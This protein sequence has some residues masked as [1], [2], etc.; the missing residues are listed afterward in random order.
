MTVNCTSMKK[1]K[2]SEL[3]WCN[4]NNST[5]PSTRLTRP[6][7]CSKSNKWLTLSYSR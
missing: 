5:W 2:G 6:D 4:A 7:S 3:C 1:G